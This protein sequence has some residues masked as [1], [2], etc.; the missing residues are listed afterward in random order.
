[1]YCSAVSFLQAAIKSNRLLNVGQHAGQLLVQV[2]VLLLL[3]LEDVVESVDL[4]LEH[5]VALPHRGQVVAVFVDLAVQSLHFLLEV[6]LCQKYLIKSN[7]IL[8][9]TLHRM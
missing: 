6:L 2:V 9:I 3:H 4:G 5:E 8:L 7:V 1:M